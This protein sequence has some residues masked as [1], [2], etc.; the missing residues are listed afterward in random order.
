MRLA[1]AAAVF[2]LIAALANVLTV[3]AAPWLINAVVMHKIAQAAGGVNRALAAP[4]A[5]AAA[6]TV[7]RPSP[8][9]LYTACVFDVSERALRISGPVPDSYASVAGFAADTSNFFAL[10]DAAVAVGADGR[11]R[12]SVLLSAIPVPAPP[13][14]RVV[15]APS[16]RG[17]ILFRT[18]ITSDTDLPR[19]REI[20]A[21][22]KC[23]ML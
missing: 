1:R 3:S 11:K 23:E 16:A 17:L 5:D 14:T 12:F 10:D 20:Q 9:L 4:R 18:L 2:V 21:Q 6:R 8:D 7:V 19:L 15:V 22:Q 13:G